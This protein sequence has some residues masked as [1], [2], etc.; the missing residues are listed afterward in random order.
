M[1]VVGRSPATA[2]PWPENEDQQAANAP[3]GFAPH[4]T[5][6]RA[7]RRHAQG[8]IRNRIRGFEEAV[9]HVDH[10]IRTMMLVARNKLMPWMTG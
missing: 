2:G 8:S 10:E 6:Y 4:Q 3:S 1:G 9:D 5:D 7:G